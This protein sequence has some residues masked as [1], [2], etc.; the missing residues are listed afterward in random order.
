[1]ILIGAALTIAQQQW[2]NMGLGAGI[3]LALYAAYKFGKLGGGDVKL[4]TAIALLNPVN[5][6]MF[7]FA[8]TILCGNERNNILLGV[9]WNK[10][11]QERN[12]LE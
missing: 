11:L 7:L 5:D 3:F 9:L 8:N 6:P 10:I 4:F 1:M 12:K 2:A